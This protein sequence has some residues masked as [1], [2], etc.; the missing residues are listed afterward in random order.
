MEVYVN[1]VLGDTNQIVHPHLTDKKVEINY[2]YTLN[3][4]VNKIIGFEDLLEKGEIKEIFQYRNQGCITE[5]MTT[6][7]D[8]VLGFLIEAD[9]VE[10]LQALRRDIVKSV[11]IKN[12]FGQSIMYK[13]C[14]YSEC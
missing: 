5:K 6:S 8:R 12:E 1:R 7:S 9:T 4:I 14:F 10:D 13:K 2:V 3:G 11:D